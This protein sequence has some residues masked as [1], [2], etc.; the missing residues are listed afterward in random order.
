M[1][2]GMTCAILYGIVL[3]YSVSLI[4]IVGFI[5]SLNYYRKIMGR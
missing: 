2:D 3:P 5:L 1:T 4:P